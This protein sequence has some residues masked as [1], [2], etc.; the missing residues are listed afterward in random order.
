MNKKE[1][2][3]QLRVGD[4]VC[5]CRYEHVEIQEITDDMGVWRPWIYRQIIFSDWMPITFTDLIDGIW[6]W[7]GKRLGIM[8][9]VDRTLI[10]KDGNSCSAKH[11]CDPVEH[12]WEHILKSEYKEENKL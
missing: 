2:I 11:C 9:L 3:R 6:E 12:E 5:D 1:W 8:I 7:I 4:K 10:L